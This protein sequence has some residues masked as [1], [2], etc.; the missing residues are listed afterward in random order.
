[1]SVVK[2]FTLNLGDF[3]LVAENIE[4]SDQGVTALL[5]PSGAGKSSFAKALLGLIPLQAGQ[6]LIK[7]DNKEIDLLKLN[8]AQRK[9]GVV[10]QDF[11]LFPH[12]SAKQNIMFAA[13]ARAV[14]DEK[15]QQL[16]EL[17][18]RELQMDKFEN[19]KAVHLSGG[20]TQ[21][22]ALARALMG[23][24]R[25][26]ILDEAFVSL[27]KDNKKSAYDLCK[28]LLSA[29]TTPALLITHD[30]EEVAAFG[31]KVLQIKCG[32]IFS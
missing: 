27:D 16:Y 6:W 13:K 8:V 18:L 28:K 17:F 25:F 31:A 29:T 30:A 1:M 21:R 22:T 23:Q 11:A 5:G 3:K 2:N 19:T 14:P 15:A 4:I 26:L 10:F 9:L 32:Q 24:P 20:E 7:E 12:M